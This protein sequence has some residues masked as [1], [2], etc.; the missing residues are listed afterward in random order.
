MMFIPAVYS[1][2]ASSLK[3]NCDSNEWMKFSSGACPWLSAIIV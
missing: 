1:L 3:T 2:K